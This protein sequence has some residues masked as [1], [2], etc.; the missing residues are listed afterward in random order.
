MPDSSDSANSRGFAIAAIDA[1]TM[2]GLGAFPRPLT[3]SLLKWHADQRL[4]ASLSYLCEVAERAFGESFVTQTRM[5]ERA[6]SSEPRA[7][8]RLRGA[9]YVLHTE[10]R[11]AIKA[12][13]PVRVQELLGQLP[14][15]QATSGDVVVRGIPPA[16][17]PSDREMQLFRSTMGREHERAYGL[18]FDAAAPP[19]EV[20]P[21]FARTAWEVLEILE[22]LDPDCAAEI[23]S[24]VSDVVIV[25]SQ[26]VNAGSSFRAF[27]Y[28]VLRE[29]EPDRAWT[30]Y[31]E[32]IV[33]EAAHLYLYLLWTH[34]PIIENEGEGLFRSPVRPGGR[35][36]SAI[37]H[38]MFVLARTIRT[39]RIVR[40]DSVY[41]EDISRMST[42]YN[43]AKNPDGF[44]VKFFEAY[45][46]IKDNA[47]LTPLGE[48]LLRGCR[49]MVE[50]T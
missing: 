39:I 12:N 42:S 21:L 50:G 19:A 48:E 17:D 34:D 29:L 20:L 43:Y 35:P 3:A 15:V 23:R 10:M 45:E 46:T 26:N 47:Q 5:L 6:A 37:F 27:G 24:V 4:L 36:L 13:D 32:S 22:R 1:D 44:E 9:M 14:T 7:E 30:T 25:K 11:H 31:L 8:R 2:D 18:P 41:R 16:S 28:I 40:E 38:A 49:A 33:H